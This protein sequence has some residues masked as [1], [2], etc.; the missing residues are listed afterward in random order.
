MCKFSIA[1]P[2]YNGIKNIAEAVESG[3]NQDYEFEVLVV[4]NN[5]NGCS[6]PSSTVSKKLC[7]HRRIL[8]FG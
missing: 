1:I 5:S 4:D 3:I 2:V 8:F 6:G 7:F